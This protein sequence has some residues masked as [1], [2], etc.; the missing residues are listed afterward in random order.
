[1]FNLRLSKSAVSVALH[2]PIDPQAP[3]SLAPST[4]DLQHRHPC[5]RF[6][7]SD[8][9]A[10][11]HRFDPVYWVSRFLNLIQFNCCMDHHQAY[12]PQLTAAQCRARASLIRRSIGS[13]SDAEL[14]VRLLD[15]AEQ[16]EELA[17]GIDRIN[18]DDDQEPVSKEI[19]F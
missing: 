11:A 3:V 17:E 1:M 19:S 16:Y 15:I 12:N 18:F 6:R 2:Q 5:R 14:R 4:A 8:R 9:A 7:S 10:G 13:N